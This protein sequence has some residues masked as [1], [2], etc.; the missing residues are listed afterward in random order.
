MASGIKTGIMIVA[1]TTSI[2]IMTDRHPV[3]AADFDENLKEENLNLNLTRMTPAQHKKKRW[4]EHEG[5]LLLVG[6]KVRY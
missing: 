2:M 5:I 1:A 3:T 6:R 4:R